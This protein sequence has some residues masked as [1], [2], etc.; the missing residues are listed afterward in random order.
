M[1]NNI[2]LNSRKFLALILPVF[3]VLVMAMDTWAQVPTFTKAFSPDTIGPGSTSTLTFTIANGNVTPVD[4]LAFSDTLPAGVVIATPSSAETTC[5]DGTLS[6]PDGGSTI[7]FSGGK[8]GSLSSCTIT[9]NV[10]SSAVGTNTNLTGDLTSDVGNSGTA[11]DDLNVLVSL[12]GFSKSF[13]PNP[14]SLGGKSTLTF[15]IDN[16]A[17]GV[18]VP[19]LDFTDNLPTGMEVASPANASTDCISALNDTTITATSGTSIIT[20]DANGA[21]FGGLRFCLPGQVV[22]L[23]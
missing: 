9:V 14:I 15:T 12:P 13:A 23:P 21:N 22:P 1:K 4:N 8:V 16:T 11:T 17:S 3:L 7:T 20:L 5:T 6:A 18:I 2:I 19:N 10:T